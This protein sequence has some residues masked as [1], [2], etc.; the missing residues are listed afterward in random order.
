[1]PPKEFRDD[2]TD[3]N[4]VSQRLNVEFDSEKSDEEIFDD[5]EESKA[6]ERKKAMKDKPK[7]AQL[8]PGSNV[9]ASLKKGNSSDS[10]LH[11]DTES[12]SQDD[13]TQN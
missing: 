13:S 5:Q 7:G 1:M 3:P 10:G 11:T 9:G 8:M 2:Q 6:N 4:D 12:S